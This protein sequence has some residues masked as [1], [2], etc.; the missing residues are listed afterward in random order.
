MSL[1]RRPGSG[2]I[3]LGELLAG[4]IANLGNGMAPGRKLPD[5]L[6]SVPHCLNPDCNKF[7]RPWRWVVPGLF[8]YPE[9]LQP[10]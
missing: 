5:L 7:E 3:A 1:A 10:H 8:R 4:G 9:R 6:G 2:M